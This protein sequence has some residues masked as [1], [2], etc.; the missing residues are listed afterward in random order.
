M[1]N[2]RPVLDFRNKYLE[3]VEKIHIK[4]KIQFKFNKTLYNINLGDLGSEYF[5]NRR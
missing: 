3:M 5:N 4:E 2:I 1:I